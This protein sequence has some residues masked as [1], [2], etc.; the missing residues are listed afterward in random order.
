MSNDDS[1]NKFCL[2]GSMVWHKAELA[3]Q[4]AVTSYLRL[5]RA[6]VSSKDIL[7]T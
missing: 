1:K 2:P 4:M 5:S 7:P 3:L 6:I